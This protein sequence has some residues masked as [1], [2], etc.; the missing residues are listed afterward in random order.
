MKTTNVMRLASVSKMMATSAVTVLYK[1]GQLTPG[2]K[3]FPYLGISSP[4]F[5]SESP[6]PNINQI[7]VQELVDH[8]AGLH[9]S[10]AGDPLFMMR[11]IEVAMG[12]EPITKQQF[13]RYI[14]GLPLL[15]TP[16]TQSVYSNVGY[17]IL[18]MVVEKATGQSFFS[19]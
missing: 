13:A 11:D 5:A 7:T 19:T 9:G 16:G 8:T 1:T 10:G 12:S 17:L 18:G 14:Y 3:V 4:L 2:L 15:S 6:D